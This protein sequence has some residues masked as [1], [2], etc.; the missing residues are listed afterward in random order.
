MTDDRTNRV[1]RYAGDR[2]ET[3]VVEPEA[4]AVLVRFDDTVKHYEVLA[5]PVEQSMEEPT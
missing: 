2:L 1:R 3:A 4:R 5:S